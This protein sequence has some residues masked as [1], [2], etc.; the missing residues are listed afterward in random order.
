MLALF[1]W[2][3]GSFTEK[4]LNEPV[5]DEGPKMTIDLPES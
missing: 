2:Q 3:I 5:E 4:A 1:G